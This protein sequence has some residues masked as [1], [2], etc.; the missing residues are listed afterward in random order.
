[1]HLPDDIDGAIHQGKS[2]LDDSLEH[3][4]K[5]LRKLRTGKASPAMVN[6]LLV[7]YYGAPTPL[8]QVS[9]VSTSD[10]RTIVIQPWEKSLLPAIEKSI[11]E[12]NMGLTPQNDG[13]VVR[14]TIPP[15]TEE[16]RKDLVKKAK[17]LGEEAKVSQRN[18]RRAIIDVIKKEVKN[19]FPEDAG[20]REE[21]KVDKL[22]HQYHDRADQYIQAKE[23]DIMTI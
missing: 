8:G 9:N 7:S 18:I 16:R 10:A 22:V 20:K 5:E 21:E 1:M 11:F 12:A 17:S 6:E 13:E 2:L 3:L 19:G 15:L 23:K 14:I 4:Q